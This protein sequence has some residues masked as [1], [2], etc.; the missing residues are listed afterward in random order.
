MGRVARGRTDARQTLAVNYAHGDMVAFPGSYKRIGIKRGGE[1]R[2]SGIDREARADTL[3]CKD[4]RAAASAPNRVG[5]HRSTGDA[6][7]ACDPG[8]GQ[9]HGPP[10]ADRKIDRSQKY[11]IRLG[12]LKV[13][14][15]CFI[16]RAT[17]RL[18]GRRVRSR[19]VGRDRFSV[20]GA[21]ARALAAGAL[22]R[23]P[24]ARPSA[25]RT[26]ALP[27]L[28][29]LPACGR[30]HRESAG[31]EPRRH[32]VTLAHCRVAES[33]SAN[34]DTL[35]VRAGQAVEYAYLP[36]A[37]LSYQLLHVDV[38]WGI[39]DEIIT[40]VLVSSQVEQLAV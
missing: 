35:I 8:N 34:P 1:R 24:R 6:R 39:L 18:S 30:Q 32:A 17:D 25:E 40:L 4:G 21:F 38:T 23:Q 19:S 13:L 14:V 31:A 5:A 22:G 11:P 20:R 10:S 28:P 37:Q 36:I 33:R 16:G 27:V 2:V 26:A 12:F 3:E 29:A 7:R 15:R 9:C